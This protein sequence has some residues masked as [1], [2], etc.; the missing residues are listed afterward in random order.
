MYFVTGNINKFNEVKSIFPDVQQLAA[1]LP[2]IQSLDPKEIIWHKL[3]EAQKLYPNTQLIVE[4][5]SLVFDARNG[6][7]WPFIKWHLDT[8]KDIGIWQMLQWFSNKS[9][10][11]MS[12]IGYT[13]GKNTEFFTWIVYGT[14]VEPV[15]STWFGR[16]AL[17]Q[18]EW[19]DKT[20]AEMTKEEKNAISHRG[21]ALQLLKECLEK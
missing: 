17:F 6:L 12:T 8:V 20:F 7:P 2:E 11:G 18:P 21:K 14:I 13:D 4:D 5:T 1:D 3:Q 15:V 16:D 9:A 10:R 19:Y